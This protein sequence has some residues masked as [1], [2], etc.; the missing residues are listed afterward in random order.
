MHEML[1]TGLERWPPYEKSRVQR[2]INCFSS[3]DEQMCCVVCMLGTYPPAQKNPERANT[4]ML[5][6]V[7]CEC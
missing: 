6:V 1:M 4:E 3:M 5:I 2:H 7:I